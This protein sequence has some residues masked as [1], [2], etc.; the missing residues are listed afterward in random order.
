MPFFLLIEM[1]YSYPHD[2]KKNSEKFF[3][4][5]MLEQATLNCQADNPLSVLIASL[6][7]R[8]VTHDTE[9]PH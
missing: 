4:N 3:E 8:M 6:E 5:S 2:I 9:C 1:K 7:K